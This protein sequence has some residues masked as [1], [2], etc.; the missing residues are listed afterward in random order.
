VSLALSLLL[1]TA[2]RLLGFFGLPLG[3]FAPAPLAVLLVRNGGTTMLLTGALGAAGLWGA[4]GAEAAAAFAF[5]VGIPGFLIGRGLKLGWPPELVVGAS[6]AL[7]S[8]FTYLGLRLA[9]PGGI[10]PWVAGLVNQTIDLYAR[11]GVPE[12]TVAMLRDRA[13]PFAD[14]FFHLL[15]LVLMTSGLA[16]GTA[17]LLSAWGWLA[18]RKEEGLAPFAPLSWHLPDIW[19]WGLIVAGVLTLLPYEG[20]KVAGQNALGVMAIAYAIQGWAVVAS[21]FHHR[22]AHALL[23]GAF[24]AVMILWP[25]LAAALVLIGLTDVWIDLR[26]VRP[27]PEPPDS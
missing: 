6:A 1:F 7:L 11:Q 2:V 12:A 14:A 8:A 20:L 13:G 4:Q 17:S 21:I 3:L 26:R 9:L 22:K 10:R 15:P 5:A 25:P 18:R 27:R 23:Q 19:I 16:L 24:Y